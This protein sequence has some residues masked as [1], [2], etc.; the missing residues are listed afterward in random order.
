MSGRCQQRFRLDVRKY[1]FSRRVVRCWNRL[2]QEVVESPSL[3]VFKE[4]LDVVLNAWFGG[5][6]W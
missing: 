3:E 4:D 2:P 5:K 1:F 6:Y